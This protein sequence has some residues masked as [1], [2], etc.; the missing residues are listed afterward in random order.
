[1]SALRGEADNQ[2]E[3]TRILCRRMLC[4][5]ALLVFVHHLARSIVVDTIIDRVGGALD[6]DVERLLPALDFEAPPQPSIR[7]RE[8]G[9]PLVLHHSGY[10]QALNHHGMVEIAEEADATIELSLKAGRHVIEGG[11]FA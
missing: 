8:G 5:V 10:I 9:A 3:V 4:S 11:V 1:M 6:A 7:P 2:V